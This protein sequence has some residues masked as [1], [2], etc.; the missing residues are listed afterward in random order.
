MTT[1]RDS[2]KRHPNSP[3]SIALGFFASC[4]AFVTPNMTETAVANG[5]TRTIY[6]HHAHTGE[7]IAATYLVNGQYDTRVLEQLNWF[8]RDWRR[9]EPTTMDPRLFDVVWEA[10]RSAGASNQ[11]INVVSAYRSPETNAM[12]RARSRAVA[13]FSQHMLGKAMDTTMPGMPMSDVREI[14]MRMQRGGVGYYPNANTP[15][16]HLDV[17]NVRSWP[18]MS[19][20]QLVRLFPD[21]KTVHLPTNGQPLPGYDVAK[22]EIE[23]RGNGA[24]V[25]APRRT[26]GGFFAAL[27][28]MSSGED[29]DAEIAAPPPSTRKQWAALAPRNARGAAADADGEEG[30]V[31]EQP[32]SRRGRNQ[33]ARAEADL[34]RGETAMTA[35]GA[36]AVAPETNRAPLTAAPPAPNEPAAEIPQEEEKKPKYARVPLPP[37]GRPASLDR[38]T[39]LDEKPTAVAAVEPNGSR[40]LRSSVDAQESEAVDAGTSRRFVNAPK[41]PRRP[42]TLAL[43]AQE[44]DAPTTPGRPQQRRNGASHA[45]AK[46]VEP[47]DQTGADDPALA[48]APDG[49]T[50]PNAAKHDAEDAKP[51]PAQKTVAEKADLVPARL[52]RSNFNTLTA[53]TPAAHVSARPVL[54]APIT[55]VRSAA[56]ATAP[57]L[58]LPPARPANIVG[59]AAPGAPPPADKFAPGGARAR[60]AGQKNEA[61][62]KN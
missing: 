36:V 7:D 32:A 53:T 26:F 15:F 8:L 54:G 23:A 40:E 58:L 25:T 20:D 41:P 29:E 42:A 19:Y 14:G 34:P 37:A 28:G 46:M 22:A 48:Y 11:V 45:I 13:K 21:G 61:G 60:S 52:D 18:R 57:S 33:L 5:D 17:G 30:G 56:R 2:D 38:P 27:F 16:V 51:K 9:D 50:K 6:L 39:P 1:P 47:E 55:A 44:A 43:A 3:R 49:D 31:A 35:T 4:M 12:L 10:Y 24:Y 59:F 62:P